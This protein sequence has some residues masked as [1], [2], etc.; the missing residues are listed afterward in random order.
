MDNFLNLANRLYEVLVGNLS[1]FRCW[2][3]YLFDAEFDDEPELRNKIGVIWICSLRD[4][5]E[6]QHRFLPQIAKEAQEQ[7]FDSLVE[8]S[9]Q[10]QNF[11]VLIAELLGEFSREE[12]IFLDDLRN[13]WVHSYFSKRHR[14]EFPVKFCAD[15]ELVHEQ[16]TRDEY[17]AVIR[18]FYANGE[19]LDEILAPM[20]SRAI[21]TK[22]HRYW[23]AIEA[24]QK[25]SEA[26]YAAFRN[27]DTIKIDV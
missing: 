3:F 9:K 7:G 24:W 18:S 1:T 25:D 2:G 22:R 21:D 26:I 12:Q 27:G 8:N 10:L 13:Q 14:E 4:S 19:S 16:I 11:C 5:I 20:I 23:Y 17:D 6:A 15:G